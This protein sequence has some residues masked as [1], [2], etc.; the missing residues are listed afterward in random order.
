MKEKSTFVKILFS[1]AGIL[2]FGG[3][4]IASDTPAKTQGTPTVKVA[5]FTY[6]PDSTSKAKS[7]NIAFALINPS[8]ASA[9]RFSGYHPFND[10]AK[11]MSQDVEQIIV[12]RGYSI[13][14][15]FST[16]DEM[17][18]GDKKNCDLL[19]YIDIEPDFN[20][21]NVK[22]NSNYH[23]IYGG[24]SYYSYSYSGTI[25]MNGKINMTVK[26]MWGE[27]KLWVKSIPM[28]QRE[29][30]IASVKS[31]SENNFQLPFASS[32]PGVV[33]PVVDA[34]EQYYTSIMMMIY[35]HLDPEEMADVKKQADEIK[36]TYQK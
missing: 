7:H 12:A 14:G 31:Y 21:Q 27:Q 25:I 5:N 23:Y 1:L 2:V 29:I 10:F 3:L 32:D 22:C 34:M 28:E 17:V 24:N 4:F 26:S 30:S 6:T 13:Y 16:T 9:F 33:N 20:I 11:A 15:P 36:K 35:A 18:Y 8:Y 19:L